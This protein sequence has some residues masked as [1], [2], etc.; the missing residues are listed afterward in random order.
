MFNLILN[1]VGFDNSFSEEKKSVSNIDDIFERFL[2]VTNAT[3][4]H[5]K[6]LSVFSTMQSNKHFCSSTAHFLKSLKSLD[7]LKELSTA[8][9]LGQVNLEEL[10]S[11]C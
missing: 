11:M 10:R 1:L 8:R 3:K 6:L 7:S 2:A 4:F 5:L 9:W